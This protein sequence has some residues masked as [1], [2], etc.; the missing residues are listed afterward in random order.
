MD[1]IKTSLAIAVALAAGV[2]ASVFAANIKEGTISFAMTV[3][4]QS[5]VS[6]TSGSKAGDWV[7]PTTHVGPT[8][9]RTHLAKIDQT[10]IIQD[11]GYVLHGSSTYYSSSAELVLVQGELSGFFNMTPELSN[12]VPEVG[13]NGLSGVILTDDLDKSTSIASST[14]SLEAL[15]ATGR[16]FQTNPITGQYPVGHLQ[17]WGQIYV[18]YTIGNSNLCDN[19]TYFFGL[20]VQECYDCF[21]LNSFISDSTFTFN[22]HVGHPLSSPPCC[23][24]GTN[25]VLQGNGRDQYY[26]TLS[27]DNTVNNPYLNKSN[28]LWVGVSGLPLPPVNGLLPD[29]TLYTNVITTNL[30]TPAPYEARFTLTGILTY[31]WNLQFVNTSDLYPDF[32]GS[33]DFSIDGY[34]FMQNY[35]T[36]L[37][38][39]VSITEDIIS[40]S[41]CCNDENGTAPWY[42]NWYGTGDYNDLGA[43]DSLRAL[44]QNIYFDWLGF[45]PSTPFNTGANLTYHANFNENYLPRVIENLPATVA[46][47]AP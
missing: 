16:H 39:T 22:K 26:M 15:L 42:D 10:T 5:S 2:S 7:D 20:T 14:N 47:P 23:N 46:P 18:K 45:T 32:V 24:I 27:F 21:Y 34:G 4:Q 38:G 43:T 37:Y 9:Y 12:S 17:P 40:S 36:L 33:A 8:R 30:V 28:A 44:N 25:A 35:C 6:E 1:N 29:Q 3:Q 11:I 31:N 13:T 41:D 19:V